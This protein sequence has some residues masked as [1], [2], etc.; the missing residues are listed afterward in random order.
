MSD[1][2][3][4]WRDGEGPDGFEALRKAAGEPPPLRADVRSHVRMQLVQ[5]ARPMPIGLRAPIYGAVAVVL[6][7][8]LVWAFRPGSEEDVNVL[9]PDTASLVDD[10]L[11]EAAQEPPTLI[12]EL[13]AAPLPPPLPDKPEVQIPAAPTMRSERESTPAT[14]V[15]DPWGD[16][17]E[18]ARAEPAAMDEDS[19]FDPWSREQPEGRLVINS[20]P[21]SRVTVDGREFGFTPQVNLRVPAGSREIVL[22]TSDGRQHRTTVVVEAGN[23]HRIIHRFTHRSRMQAR[24]GVEV[25][26]PWARAPAP[27]TNRGLLHISSVPYAEVQLDGREI[28]STPIQRTLRSGRHRL[29]LT[30]E[31]GKV[32]ERNVTVRAGEITRVNHRFSTPRGMSYA[33]EVVDP[34]GP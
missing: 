15:L 29:V 10:A 21:W 33:G 13:P 1:D 17:R 22:T 25:L 11:D 27:E 26:D 32:H 4:R 30:T 16:D 20:M 8:V 19:F 24:S 5:T 3:V 28:G 31:D 2:P 18:T 7:G 6:G 34:W 9:S 14:E 23:T 12:D